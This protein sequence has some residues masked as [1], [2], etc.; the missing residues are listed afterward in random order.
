MSSHG[1]CFYIHRQ[2]LIPAVNKVKGLS[3]VGQS[4][5]CHWKWGIDY[6]SDMGYVLLFDWLSS[7]LLKVFCEDLYPFFS[8]GKVAWKNRNDMEEL[9]VT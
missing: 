5:G 9:R 1:A 2:H 8:G 3:S 4:L 7:F 6:D